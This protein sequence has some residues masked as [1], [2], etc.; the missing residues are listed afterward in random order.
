MIELAVQEVWERPLPCGARR[1]P[2][3]TITC[4]KPALHGFE[5]KL[6]PGHAH[7]GRG[8]AGQWYFWIGPW[9]PY[10]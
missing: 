6:A 5:C 2:K 10:R 7:A 1:G 8:R 4:E 3:S 9:S